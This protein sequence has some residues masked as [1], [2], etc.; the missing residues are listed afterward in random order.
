M[1]KWAVEQCSRVRRD[2]DG[3]R[4]L[5]LG[6]LIL[7]PLSGGYWSIERSARGKLYLL[8]AWVNADE[9]RQLLPSCVC[10]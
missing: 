5:T 3:A 8:A 2:E 6:D 7:T 9:V 4:Y 1:T 10:K